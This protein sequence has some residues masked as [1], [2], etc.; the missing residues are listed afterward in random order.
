VVGR[1]WLDGGMT[2]PSGSEV[3]LAGPAMVPLVRAVRELSEAGLG[4]FAVVGGVA[5]SARLGSAHRATADVDTVVDE[6]TPPDAVEALLARDHAEA[7]PVTPHRVFLH[8]TK[9]EILGVGPLEDSDLA[10]LPDHDAL[11]VAAHAWGLERATDLTITASDERGLRATAPFATASGLVAMKLHAIQTRSPASLHKRGGDAWDLYRL[12]VDLDG[13]GDVRGDLASAPPLMRRLLI[14]AVQ[15]VL[16]DGAART[17]GWLR[18]SDVATGPVS[19]E[20]LRFL[21]APLVDALG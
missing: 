13:S 21:A 17:V 3:V 14:E 5:V 12:L 19:A 11:F 8:G 15:R 6:T 10:D 2:M 16:I 4:R 7:D 9:V 18:V 1:S 20:E